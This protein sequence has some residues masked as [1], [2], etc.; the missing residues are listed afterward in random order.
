MRMR[1]LIIGAV[2]LLSGSLAHAACVPGKSGD[3][4]SF[5]AV[6]AISTQIVADEEKGRKSQKRTFAEPV[7]PPYTGPTVGVS[8]MVRRA[9]TVG[10][11]WSLQ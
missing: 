1:S 9:P 7:T 8:S 10:Y 2:A 11:R 5:S 4:V 6:P 3:C